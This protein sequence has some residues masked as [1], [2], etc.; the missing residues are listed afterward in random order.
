M[1]IRFPVRDKRIFEAPTLSYSGFRGSCK[2]M[3]LDY[4]RYNN[5]LEITRFPAIHEVGIAGYHMGTDWF[6]IRTHQSVAR[7]ALRS[8]SIFNRPNAH[9]A[10]AG[11]SDPV[12]ALSGR[13]DRGGFR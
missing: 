7:S 6:P 10:V 4:L 2:R 12:P 13:P 1:P 9:V 11:C 3:T 5:M 8:I